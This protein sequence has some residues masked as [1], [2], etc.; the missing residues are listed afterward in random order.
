MRARINLKRLGNAT[1]VV[2]VFK[3]IDMNVSPTETGVYASFT[4][5]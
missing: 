4:G 5:Y 3:V 2:E 1:Y